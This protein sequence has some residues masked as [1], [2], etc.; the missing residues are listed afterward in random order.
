MEDDLSLLAM[1]VSKSSAKITGSLLK[2]KDMWSSL[3][4]RK[5]SIFS[6]LIFFI[7]ASMGKT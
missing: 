6:S 7:I 4:V 3:V 2:A 1:L 5:P